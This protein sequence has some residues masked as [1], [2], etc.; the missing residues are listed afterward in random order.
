[1]TETPLPAS[2]RTTSNSFSVSVSVSA[3]VG[4]SRIRILQ[5]A[6]QRLGDLDDLRLRRRKRATLSAP[7]RW[8][9]RAGRS[10]P[11]RLSRMRADVDLAEPF[12][13]LPAGKDVLGDRKLRH[14]R[15]FLVDDADAEVAGGLFVER[16]RFRRR[17]PGRCPGRANR[18]R[19][20]SCRASTC[21]RRSRRAARGSRRPRR[22]SR[23]RRA[24]ARRGRTSTGSLIV[25][26]RRHGGG[27]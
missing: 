15:A 4:S 3:A 26:P 10:A 17:R 8:R 27:T 11:W 1:M 7:G 16:R 5:V 12:R 18:R 21:R 9:R 25:E 19:R 2:R 22:S 14:Q 6:R 13:R 20:R 24:P 23:R